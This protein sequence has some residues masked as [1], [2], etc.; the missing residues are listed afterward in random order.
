VR[1]KLEVVAEEQDAKDAPTETELSAYLAKHA[2]RFTSPATASFDQIVL[3]AGE[4]E[5]DVERAAAAAK[6]ALLRGAD[7]SRIGRASMLPV[8]VKASRL[9]LV[10]REFGPTFAG[11]LEKLPAHEWIGP[12]RSDFGAHLVRV[13]EFVPGALPPLEAVRTA[14]TRQW[15]DERRAVAR[16]ES[17]RKVRERYEVVIEGKQMPSVATR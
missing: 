16:S 13:A 2:E 11:Q 10:A 4:A 14:V 6:S 17:Y 9:D 3:D 5:G 12:I 15:E 7:P 1:R 8:Q